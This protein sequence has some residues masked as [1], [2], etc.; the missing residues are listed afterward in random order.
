MDPNVAAA[1]IRT[2]GY[3]VDAAAAA[4]RFSLVLLALFAGVAL[5]MAAV[6]IYGVVSYSVA[7]RTR[8]TGVRLALGATMGDILALVLGEGLRRTVAGHRR[9]P[10]RRAPGHPRPGQPALRGGGDGSAH[11]RR[12]DRSPRGRHPRRLPASGLARRAVEPAGGPARLKRSPAATGRRRGL[13]HGA[14][15][16]PRQIP[17]SR[18]VRTV[19]QSRG[20]VFIRLVAWARGT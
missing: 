4:R 12:R 20:T 11:L 19:S 18:A 8:E 2:T 7:Q 15:Q 5:V 9:R 13:A 6:G 3:Y 10:G 17:S 1:D 14:L 16:S